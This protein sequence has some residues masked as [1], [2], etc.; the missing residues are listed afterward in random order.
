MRLDGDIAPRCPRDDA[1]REER[2]LLRESGPRLGPGC[3]DVEEQ[4][5]E[6]H[7]DREW[8]WQLFTSFVSFGIT[9]DD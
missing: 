6:R 9:S 3:D 5:T 4:A 1:L 2:G 7:A 8:V